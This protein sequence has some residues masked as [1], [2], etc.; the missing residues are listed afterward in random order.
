[1]VL[2]RKGDLLHLKWRMALKVEF[3]GCQRM[4]SLDCFDIKEYGSH[5]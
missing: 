1:M 3:A 2:G 5:M 4:A